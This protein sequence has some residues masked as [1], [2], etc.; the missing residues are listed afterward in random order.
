MPALV[1][2]SSSSVYGL[3][4]KSPF[5]EDDRVDQPASLYAATKKV[6]NA[7]EIIWLKRK[8]VQALND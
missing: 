6:G 2:A 1:F 5:S 7:R 3:N 4:K 8:G